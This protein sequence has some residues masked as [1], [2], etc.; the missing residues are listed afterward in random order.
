MA[1]CPECHTSGSNWRHCL[2]CGKYFC[3]RCAQKA[4]II[5]ASNRCPYCEVLNKVKVEQPK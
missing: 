3:F 1:T 4:K 2:A 5:K